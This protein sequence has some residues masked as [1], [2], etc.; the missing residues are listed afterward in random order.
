MPKPI[1]ESVIAVAAAAIDDRSISSSELGP[2]LASPSDSTITRLAAL[3]DSAPA[4]AGTPA[5]GRSPSRSSRRRAADRSPPGSLALGAA[6]GRQ[7]HLGRAGVGDERHRVA[8]ASSPTSAAAT[9]G[10]P[11]LVGRVHRARH[12]DQEHQV[13]RRALVSGL[14]GVATPTRTM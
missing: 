8:G 6:G 11:E 13:H 3:A 1:V 4:P 10:E 7:H 2:T 5:R 14:A 12:V 9:L